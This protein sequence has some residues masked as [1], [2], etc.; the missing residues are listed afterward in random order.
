M[1][2]TNGRWSRDLARRAFL[3]GLSLVVLGIALLA[4]NAV[5]QFQHDNP[6]KCPATPCTGDPTPGSTITQ[7]PVPPAVVY[8]PQD[9]KKEDGGQGIAAIITATGGAIA[10]VLGA[11]AMLLAVVRQPAGGGIFG[12]APA[13]PPGVSEPN[14]SQHVAGSP[15]QP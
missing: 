4:G 9:N 13:G 2:A 1:W 11:L 10:A 3:A 6:D 14:G 8:I 7:T 5:F 15:D 12:A